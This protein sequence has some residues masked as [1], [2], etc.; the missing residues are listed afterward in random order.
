MTSK[1]MQ[2]IFDIG[3]V[4]L[5]SLDDANDAVPL[6]QALVKGGIPVAEVTFRT[7][8]G[9]DSIREMAAKVPDI[10]VGAGTVHDIAHA[11]QA[12]DAGAKFIVTPGF[13]PSVVK[14]CLDNN[15][16]VVPGTA[17][18][19]DIEAAMA[20]GLNTCKF[21]PAEAYGGTK[22]LKALSGPFSGISFMP[23]GGVNEENMLDYLS[24]PNVVAVG[25]SFMT[26]SSA[27][28]AKNWDNIVETCQ[29]ILSRLLGF[30]LAHVGINCENAKQADSV[31]SRLAELFLQE[32]IEHDGAYFAGS[33]AEVI[34]SPFLG[35]NGHLCID[36]NDMIRAVAYFRRKGIKFN[37]DTW[38]NDEKG[39][40]K[41]VYL[42]EEVGGFCIHLRQKAK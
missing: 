38:I 26:P 3:L 1:N 14:W 20:M 42:A 28:K 19:A 18:P 7:A 37:D 32:K 35:K 4:P 10:I 27:I 22:T 34:K 33:M 36:T 8:A 5:I 21:F 2:D 25:G 6:A 15:I 16:D 12:I 39:N 41:V 11:E 23:T 9:L 40:P 13:N 24:L 30:S 29:Q 17:S 31:T